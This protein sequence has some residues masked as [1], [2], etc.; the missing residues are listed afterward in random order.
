MCVYNYRRVQYIICLAT[1]VKRLFA[2]LSAKI[3]LIGFE[4][5]KTSNIFVMTFSI[6]TPSEYPVLSVSPNMRSHTMQRYIQLTAIATIR[7][8][9]T[10]NTHTMAQHCQSNGTTLAEN[11]HPENGLLF[12]RSSTI[13]CQLCDHSQ[14]KSLGNVYFSD[15]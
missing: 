15:R 6:T 8:R 3:S 5:M 4:T 7:A 11:S 14:M 2:G 1:V 10:H 9:T 12:H 13:L